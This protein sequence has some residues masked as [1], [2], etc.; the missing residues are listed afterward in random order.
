MRI[1]AN[2]NKKSVMILE[3]QFMYFLFVD[4]TILTFIAQSLLWSFLFYSNRKCS[5]W[6]KLIILF[7]PLITC[8]LVSVYLFIP[9]MIM[10]LI[11]S[12]S[13]FFLCS[14]FLGR[15][16]QRFYEHGGEMQV[17]QDTPLKPY[18]DIFAVGWAFF[19]ARILS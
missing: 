15:C 11:F 3:G 9:N 18:M 19:T 6:Q 10:L 17:A 7:V 14:L 2:M 5:Y 13:L 12:F 16:F 1:E 8:F 4:L